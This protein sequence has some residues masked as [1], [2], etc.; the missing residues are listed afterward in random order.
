M[1]F[2]FQILYFIGSVAVDTKGKQTNVSFFF[3]W[4]NSLFGLS[5]SLTCQS[6]TVIGIVRGGGRMFVSHRVG[7][8]SDP[9]INYCGWE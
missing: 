4:V 5:I 9:S 7:M 1:M 6:I 8:V 3:I 2:V